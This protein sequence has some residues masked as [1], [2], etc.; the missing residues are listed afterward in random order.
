MPES[1][2]TGQGATEGASGFR[3][4]IAL[5]D[6]KDR[7]PTAVTLDS[8]DEVCVVRV[9]DDVFAVPDRCTHADYPLSDG[10]MLGHGC[11]IECVL[12]GAVFDLSDGSVVEGP[13]VEPLQRLQVEVREGVV[14]IGPGGS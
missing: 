5:A 14:W 9:G 4:A 12:H 11:E 6:L 1:H 3:R 2:E 13:A 7:R 8:G 10:E